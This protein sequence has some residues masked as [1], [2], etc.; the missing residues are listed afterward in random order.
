MLEAEEKYDET[1]LLHEEEGN[2]EIDAGR[3]NEREPVVR[4]ENFR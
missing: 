2:E 3:G 4:T 1:D